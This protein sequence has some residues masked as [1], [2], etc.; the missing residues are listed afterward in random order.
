MSEALEALAETAGLVWRFHDGAGQWREAPD[1]SIRAVL[2][3]LGLAAETEGDAADT[4]RSLSEARQRRILPEWMV[5]R[6]DDAPALEMA[7][8]GAVEWRL[9]CADGSL[10]EGRAE[11][12]LEPGHLPLGRHRL[13]LGDNVTTLL[14]APDRL[15]EA[16]RGWGVTLPLY[17]LRPEAGGGLGTYRDLGRAAG[18]LGGMG[19]GFLGINPV[20]AGFP[21]DPLNYSPYA[22]SS[23]RHLNVMHIETGQEGASDESELIEYPEAFA[24]RGKALNDAY[25]LYRAGLGDPAF[26]AWRSGR[27]EELERFA[28]HQALSDVHGA[29]WTDWPQEYRDRDAAAVREFAAA[30]DDRVSFHAWLQWRA[31]TQLADAQ[32]EAHGAGMHYGLY[33]DLAVGAHPSGAE[34]WADPEHF[35]RGVSLG[36]PP[37]AFS[38]DGQVWGV[39]PLSP[40]ALAQSGF[41]VLADTLR[42]QF[43]FS[44][45]LRIDHILGFDRAFWCPEGLPGLYVMMPKRAMLAVARI[46]AARAGASIVGED[47]GNIPDGLRADLD[48]SGILGCRVAVFEREWQGDRGFRNSS[49]YDPQTLASFASHDLPTWRGWRKGLDIDW[50]ARIGH[51]DGEAAQRERH[52]RHDD[53][54]AFGRTIENHEGCVDALHAFLGRSASRLVALQAEDILGLEEQANLPGTVFEHPNWRRRL[55][56]PASAFSSDDRFA[57]AA[58]IMRQSGR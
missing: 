24:R 44:G 55:P 48:A 46:E 19:A 40:L 45:L 21:N 2:A 53:V 49:T 57:R 6:A 3:A 22:P 38:A 30:N 52:A 41:A 25:A 16:P 51:M 14:A 13:F 33:L 58:D 4:L 50:R 42:E 10:R 28:I 39:A 26:D 27:G 34:T 8:H 1:D 15:P 7:T 47:L 9:E 54:E 23:R 20:H 5:V 56:V 29:Y 43:R 12:R 37:D 17:G 35:A 32:R 11:G 18:A 36:A 31:E